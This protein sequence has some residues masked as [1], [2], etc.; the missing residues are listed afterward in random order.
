MEKS[1]KAKSK[2]LVKEKAVVTQQHSV[3]NLP[4]HSFW[5]SAKMKERRKRICRELF[6]MLFTSFSC[7][8]TF[9]KMIIFQTKIVRKG[10][11]RKFEKQI[12]AKRCF[13]NSKKS[14]MFSTT[15]ITF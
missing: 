4:I 9:Q 8:A 15:N 2:G 6:V 5:C 12:N 13:R 7:I 10:V 1:Q 11:Q 3:V 14:K